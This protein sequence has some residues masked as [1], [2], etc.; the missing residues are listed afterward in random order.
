MDPLL[1]ILIVNWNTRDLLLDCLRSLREAAIAM[2]FELI[3]VDNASTDGSAEAVSRAFPEARLIANAENVGFARANNQALAESRGEL[4]L[5]LNPDTVVAP[6]QIERMLGYMQ[7]HPRCGILGPKLLNPDGSF[8]LSA[9]PFIE[10]WDLYWEYA[11]FPRS[12]QPRA[13]KAP[14]RLYPFEPWRAMPVDYV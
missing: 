13:Q 9:V 8:Q 11:R 14:R 2:P 7:A 4:L 6:G 3:V 1:S 10:P 5:L 12:L